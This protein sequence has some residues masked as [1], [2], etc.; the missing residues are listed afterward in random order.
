[1]AGALRCNLPVTLV[2]H[3]TG[4]HGFDLMDDS[5]ASREVV[6]AMLAFLQAKLGVELPAEK[7]FSPPSVA[8][9]PVAAK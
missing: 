7:K 1:M 2:N 6:R 8:A 4:P 5:E 3:A 9:G